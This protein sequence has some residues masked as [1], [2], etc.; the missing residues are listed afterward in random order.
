MLTAGTPLGVSGT[1][2]MIKVVIIGDTLATGVGVGTD[3][4]CGELSVC[5]SD[6]DAL[7]SFKSES[8][9]VIPF[10]TNKII[11]VVRS[12]KG[13]IC[14]QG[15]EDS[16]AAIIGRALNIPVIVG[17]AGATKILKSG[18]AVT[19]DA[20]KGIVFNGDIYK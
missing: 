9:L 10:T 20:K 3:I 12:A 19:L 18:T 7:K 2:N 1:T 16:H 14:E 6:E 13:I 4:V 8:I 11:D 15:G 5:Q 17:A